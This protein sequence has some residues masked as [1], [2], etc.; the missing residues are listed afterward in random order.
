MVEEARN[1]KSTK[2]NKILNQAQ[3]AYNTVSSKLN[4]IESAVSFVQFTGFES[5]VGIQRFDTLIAI[6]A[7]VS[8]WEMSFIMQ[9]VTLY[10]YFV[11]KKLWC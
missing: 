1:N 4:A 11:K 9:Y 6:E 3:E 10:M 5:A 8:K 2:S 7:F